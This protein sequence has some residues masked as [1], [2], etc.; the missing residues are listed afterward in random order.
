MGML[1]QADPMIELLVEWDSQRQ[2]GRVL[3]PEELCPNDPQLQA[4]LRRRIARRKSMLGLFDA[5]S[6]DDAEPR[7]T[8]PLPEIAGY[9]I[10]EMIGR[11]GMGVVY[12]ARQLGLNR[13][14]ALKMVL[15]GASA[16]SLEL[17]RFRAEAQSVAQLQHPN[18]VQIFDV[19]EQGGCPYLAL[20]FVESG[21]LAEQLDGTPMAPRQAAELVLSLA[22]AVHHAHERGIVHRDLKPANVL[23]QA[24][25]TPKITDFGLAKRTES[26]VAHTQTGAILGSPSYMAP[27]QA[28]GAAEISPATDVYALGAILYELLTGRPPFKAPS[29]METIE[30]VREHN[31]VPPRLLQP[32]IPRD[33]EIICLKC[34]EKNPQQRYTSAALLADDLRA[35]LHDEPITARSLTV[36]DHVARSLSHHSFD[37][38]FREFGNRMLLFAPFPLVIH[39]AAYALLSGK[40]YFPAAIVATTATMLF[41]LLPL[42]MGLPTLRMIPNWQRNHFVTVW[43][44]HL[45]AMAVLLVVVLVSMPRDRPELLLMVYPLWAASAAIAF[46][47]HATEAGVYYLVGAVIFGVAILMAL[48]PIWAPLEI[49][50]IMTV[51]LAA[52]ALYLKRQGSNPGSESQRQT[53]YATTSKS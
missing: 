44:S 51:N 9:D 49:G 38:R 41:I 19:G 23:I 5:P 52:Q 43:I 22:R 39:V 36:L 45:I 46:L 8:P 15:A 28:T 47:A 48:T 31:A 29:I 12:K 13:L 17:A 6:L 1:N 32:K 33:L 53:P 26:T 4:E 20:E 16:S 2:Q 21:S 40:P 27:E 35:Y 14:V 11:G 42:A 7:A 37:E 18:I 50:L 30:Q 34:L 3:S 10:L 24:D 25:G